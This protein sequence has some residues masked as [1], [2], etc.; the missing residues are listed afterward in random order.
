MSLPFG[1]TSTTS[2][3][4]V[5]TY[6]SV[7][8][9]VARNAPFNNRGFEHVAPRNFEGQEKR[10][11]ILL[12]LAAFAS[13]KVSEGCSCLSIQPKTTTTTTATAAAQVRLCFQFSKCP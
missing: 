9:V 7:C 13:A 10:A 11:D 5:T 12:L 6:Q 1:S 8:G 4:T 3:A 2:T